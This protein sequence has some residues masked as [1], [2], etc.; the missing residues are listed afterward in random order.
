MLKVMLFG[1]VAWMCLFCSGCG[2][3]EDGV[4]GATQV[5]ILDF[6]RGLLLV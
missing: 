2:P 6:V 5:L 1:G 3:I 4:A